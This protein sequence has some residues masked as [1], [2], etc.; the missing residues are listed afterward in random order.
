MEANDKPNLIRETDLRGSSCLNQDA[1][2]SYLLL[3]IFPFVI[4]DGINFSDSHWELYTLFSAI[5]KICFASVVC[6]ETIAQLKEDVAEYLR[7]FKE[8]FRSA[9]HSKT[10]LPCPFS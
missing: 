1:A 3:R 6:L 8:L 9:F 2:K 4:G 10:A 5:T 7:P